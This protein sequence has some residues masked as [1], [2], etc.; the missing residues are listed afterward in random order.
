MSVKQRLKIFVLLCLLISALLACDVV[1]SISFNG[2]PVT[3][4]A[5]NAANQGLPPLNTW[6]QAGSGIELRSEQWTSPGNNQ[7]TVVITRIDPHRVHLKIAYLPN[8][9][10]SM[11]AWMKKMQAKVIINGGYF[12]K[13]NHPTGLLVD[14]GQIF[15]SSYQ[16]FGG[17]FAV[18]KQGNV[19]VSSLGQQPYNPNSADLDEATQSAPMLVVNGKRTQFD[20]NAASQRRTVIATDKQGRLLFITSSGPAFTLDELA[21]LLASSDLSINNALNLDGGASTALYVNTPAQKVNIDSFSPLPIV[22]VVR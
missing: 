8:D 7:D 21:D 13:N 22:L 19:T 17:M 5:T 11:S 18:D 1:P 20:A 2:T 14:D 3:S 9:P 15:G 12:D 10:L 16:G 6:T 4:S